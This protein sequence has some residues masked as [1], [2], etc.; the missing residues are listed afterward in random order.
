MNV[1]PIPN[2]LFQTRDFRSALLRWYG[3]HGRDLPWRHTRDPYA[4]L[5]SEIMLQQT[6]VATVIPYYK[7]WLR[8]F[9]DF[10]AL[11]RA[12]ESEVLHAWQ[13][14]GYY[15]R[16]RN[17][18]AAATRISKDYG[19]RCPETAAELAALPGLGRYTTNAILTF[20]FDQPVAVVEANIVRL[21]ARIFDVSA[22]VDTTA[23]RETIWTHAAQLVPPQRAGE[24]N[25]ALMDLGATICLPRAPQC[26]VCPAKPFCRAT[27]PL[28]L[29]RKKPRPATK[30]LTERHFFAMQRGRVLLQHCH[31]RWRGMWMLPELND[32]SKNA[33]PFH[34]STF[35]F[36][37]HQ[38]TLEVFSGAARDTIDQAQQWFSISALD[39]IPIPSPHRRAL[40]AL[41]GVQKEGPR[42]STPRPREAATALL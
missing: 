24:F 8:R 3:N 37:H 34:T 23:G 5:V 30:S 17:L 2:S 35:P 14:L 42:Q 13:G 21:L 18:H 12:T 16:A 40:D 27:E 19:S 7:E 26:G 4:I 31:K 39:S 32:R 22:P 38:V 33:R 9:P 25:S 6:Q 1:G 10:R 41:L 29:P 20:A 36:T 28:K 15:S 11:A